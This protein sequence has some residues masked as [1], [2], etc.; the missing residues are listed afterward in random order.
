[1]QWLKLFTDARKVLEDGGSRIGVRADDDAIVLLGRGT[2]LLVSLPVGF[3]TFF[4]AV[5]CILAA[6]ATIGAGI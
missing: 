2:S 4:A 5:E 3:L 6:I 1:M